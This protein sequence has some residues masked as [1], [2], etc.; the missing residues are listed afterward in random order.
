M[1]KPESTT[2]RKR[3][4]G[5]RDFLFVATLYANKTNNNQPRRDR[6]T[7]EEKALE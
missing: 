6:E 2:E 1:R 7:Q 4:L 5:T 3:K